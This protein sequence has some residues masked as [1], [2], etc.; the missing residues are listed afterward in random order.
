MKLTDNFTLAELTVTSTGL[1]NTPNTQQ[2]QNLQ[3]LC[4]NVL[5]PARNILGRP[6]TVTSGFR[7][8][9]VNRAVGGSTTSDHAHGKAA[10]LVCTDNK[11]LFE[12]LES[13]DNFDQLIW[14]FGSDSRPEWVH[15]SYRKGANR[16]MVRR[17]RKVNG[18]TIYTRL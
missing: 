12:I 5:Q 9:A 11:K 8:L 1:S 4:T 2:I 7:S 14:E 13:M 3:D 17:A 6:I 15:V 10:D 16:K 18:K